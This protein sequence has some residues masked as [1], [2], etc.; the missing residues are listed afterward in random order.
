[1]EPLQVA[2]LLHSLRAEEYACFLAL[3]DVSL[4]DVVSTSP[5]HEAERYV[6]D[7]RAALSWLLEDVSRDC[8][9]S[10]L[11]GGERRA[12]HLLAAHAESQAAPA[13][14]GPSPAQNA[15]GPVAA[16][17]VWNK[18]RRAWAPRDGAAQQAHQRFAAA[19]SRALC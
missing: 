10:G 13:S 19:P 8:M 3:P 12:P 7:T 14:C 17:Y 2:K 1:M 18:G 5:E 11:V 4:L 9:R 15:C 16:I 6:E